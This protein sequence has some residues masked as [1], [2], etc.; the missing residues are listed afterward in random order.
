MI[1]DVLRDLGRG[2]QLLGVVVRDLKPELI[3]NAHDD[4]HVIKR[5]QAQ[6]VDE[7]GLRGQL[8]RKWTL[9]SRSR[10]LAAGIKAKVMTTS[11][12][13]L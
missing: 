8:E 5:V 9:L 13:P 3:F 2:E 7:V 4:F 12:L 11:F 6:V 1:C 10:H